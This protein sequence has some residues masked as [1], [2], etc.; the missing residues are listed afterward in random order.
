MCG[1]T[2][3]PIATATS[4]PGRYTI[5]SGWPPSRCCRWWRALVLQATV[6]RH[7]ASCRRSDGG[8][9]AIDV[10]TPSSASLE[11][12]RLKVEKAAELARMIPETKATNSQVNPGGGRVYVDIGKS[13]ERSRAGGRDRRRHPRAPQAPGGRRV[14]GAG[15]SSTTA[16]RSRCRSSSMGR[17]RGGSWP[18]PATSWSR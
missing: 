4:S 13:N 15:R 6:G 12:S 3:S 17:T 18:S 14:R 7:R 8:M 16:R 10:R 1:S 5:A 2:T 9:V 11:Y